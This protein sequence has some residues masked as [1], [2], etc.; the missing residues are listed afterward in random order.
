[1]RGAHGDA[2]TQA[3]PGELSGV[4]VGDE[5]ALVEGDDA[6][7]G[8]GGL[9]GVGGGEQDGSALGRVGAQDAVQPAALAGGE[10]VGGVVEDEGVRVGEECAGEAEPPVHAAGEGAQAFVAQADE[11]D[12]FE[13]FVGAA[14]RHSG[15][16]AEHAQM[17]ADGAGGVPGHIAEEDADLAGGVG[18]AVQGAASE[19]GESAALLEF[20]HESER[21]GLA[22][23]GC[24]EQSGDS[25]GVCLEGDVVDGGRKIL[26]RVAGQSDGL[27]H[28]KQD[29]AV[30]PV[31]RASQGPLPGRDSARS[32][33]CSLFARGPGPACAPAARLRLP[34]AAS[35][36]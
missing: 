22:R 11:A 19:V 29:S 34:G 26:A 36:G 6:V 23:S 33:P 21:C 25:A 35:G 5:P 14:H 3:G 27:D 20:E 28:P 9:L 18:D 4:L 13:D 30:C 8:A 16:G 24:T 2:G 17:A 12:D 7:G 32:D 1:M 15:R 10:S 31:F